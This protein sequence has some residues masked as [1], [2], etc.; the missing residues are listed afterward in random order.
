MK[1]RPIASKSLYRSCIRGLA[2]ACH[3]P[4]SGFW[5]LAFGGRP[6]AFTL[7]ELMVVVAVIAL[8]LMMV[9]PNIR[10]MREKAWSTH[11]QN[12]LRQYGIAMN[13]YMADHGGYFIYPGRGVGGVARGDDLTGTDVFGLDAVYQR[14]ALHGAT[15]GGQRPDWWGSLIIDYI[16]DR[17]TLVTLSGGQPSV[18]VCPAVL[19][20]FKK[21]NF[22]DPKSAN[23]KGTGWYYDSVLLEDREWSDFEDVSGAC[24]D[25][26]GNLLPDYRDKFLDA[27]FTTY[28]I[29][30][31]K[32]R[33]AASNC[34]AHVIAFIDWNAR[35]GWNA[36]LCGQ[37]PRDRYPSRSED[38]WKWMFNNTNDTTINVNNDKPSS[39]WWHT[40]VGFH[41]PLNNE[42]GAN[43]LAMDASVG[44]ISSNAISRTNF[45]GF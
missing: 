22:F 5:R 17:P 16:K 36:N 40:E 44:W 26:S 43:Y 41:H 6:A 21:G 25:D 2:S 11:C 23:F 10:T 7:V 35:E 9:I 15:V 42:Y 34:P 3:R 33:Q 12:N 28:A 29:N 8:L 14:G 37:P 27:S 13:Q 18:R 38:K 20:D 39:N 4:A 24:W 31:L 1:L 32:I 45:A 19:Q 30:S